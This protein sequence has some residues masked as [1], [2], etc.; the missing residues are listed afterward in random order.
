MIAAMLGGT[1]ADIPRTLFGIPLVLSANSPLQITLVDAANILYSDTD[2][3][4]VSTS[5]SALLE[6]DSAP[7]E[8]TSA[9]TVMTSLYQRN[10]WAVKVLARVP[11]RANRRG[12]LHGHY[13]LSP[14]MTD[15][16]LGDGARLLDAMNRSELVRA[17][18]KAATAPLTLTD[19]DFVT[20]HNHGA[21]GEAAGA[22]QAR[23]AAQPAIVHQH[24]PAPLVTKN[25]ETARAKSLTT[26]LSPDQFAD[27]V[28]ESIKGALESPKVKGRFETLERRVS[29]LELANEELKARVLEL[30]AHRAAVGHVEQS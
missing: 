13:L 19:G 30:E 6:L 25:A 16:I 2:G 24:Q 10:L 8:P 14:M 27:V 9:A 18:T 26:K 15:D 23:Q 5:E 7:S 17:R 3:V 22:W 28:V 4:D 21:E 29:A 20:L 12:V 11:A 1:A